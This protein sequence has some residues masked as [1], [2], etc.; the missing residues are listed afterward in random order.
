MQKSLEQM[1][2]KLHVVISDILGKTGMQMVEAIIG[3]ERDPEKLLRFK[4]GRIKASDQ[5]ILKSLNGIWKEEY[6]FMLG[7]AFKEYQFYQ[8]QMNECDEKIEKVLLEMAAKKQDGDIT[9]LE[10]KKC[11]KKEPVQL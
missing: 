1:N 9:G 6:L 8:S 2:I 5:D 10:K 3:G 11:N 4:D 7:Q